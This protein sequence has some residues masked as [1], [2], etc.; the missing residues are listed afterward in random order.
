MSGKI[1]RGALFGGGE[2]HELML[3]R[4][5]PPSYGAEWYEGFPVAKSFGQRY[6]VFLFGHVGIDNVMQ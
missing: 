5:I 4:V 3:M 1:L 6:L 2:N